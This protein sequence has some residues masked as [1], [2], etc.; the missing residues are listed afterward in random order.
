MKRTWVTVTLLVAVAALGAVEGLRARQWA[1]RP[2]E[3]RL[4]ER[5][6]AESRQS[7]DPVVRAT[8]EAQAAKLYVRWSPRQAR[9]WA[10][11]ALATFPAEKPAAPA[12]G[13]VSFA[14]WAR[15]T[16]VGVSRASLLTDVA[17]VDPQLALR[18]LGNAPNE[19]LRQSITMAAALAAAQTD[20]DLSRSLSRS[21]KDPGA[22]ASLELVLWAAQAQGTPKTA[23]WKEVEPFLTPVEQTKEPRARAA[24]LV[25]MGILARGLG[26]PEVW[27]SRL[28]PVF[29]ATLGSVE[30]PEDLGWIARGC[31]PPAVKHDPSLAIAL[32]AELQRALLRRTLPPSERKLTLAEIL[33][34]AKPEEAVRLVSELPAGLPRLAPLMKVMLDMPDGHPEAAARACD[35]MRNGLQSTLSPTFVRVAVGDI[36]RFQPDQALALGR[37]K[38][39]DVAWIVR[40]AAPRQP[41][42]ALAHLDLVP[43]PEDRARVVLAAVS[44]RLDRSPSPQPGTRRR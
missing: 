37:Q 33:A 21:V 30:R 23:M 32:T 35:L 19:D 11:G 44:A 24:S 14:E 9:K 6:L 29:R 3:A 40:A 10:R 12:K 2:A 25:A 26:H 20:P 31:L 39:V 18:A 38:K 1:N 7:S 36:A 34:F 8:L 13:D 42:W 41:D 43:K 4:V 27:E 28:L 16:A 22:R 15:Q 17:A 5:A